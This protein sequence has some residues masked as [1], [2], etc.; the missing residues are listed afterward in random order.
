MSEAARFWL[1]CFKA[2]HFMCLS[3]PELMASHGH[4]AIT[5]NC[6]VIELVILHWSVYTYD[7]MHVHVWDLSIT[8]ASNK[9]SSL[10]VLHVCLLPSSYVTHCHFYFVYKSVYLISV[11]CLPLRF[12]KAG[13]YSNDQLLNN[14]HTHSTHLNSLLLRNTWKR[15]EGILWG[16]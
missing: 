15:C 9:Y 6:I 8:E 7:A 4:W 14:H 16:S 11:L 12:Y 10:T 1:C 3:C 2:K 5:V 13:S